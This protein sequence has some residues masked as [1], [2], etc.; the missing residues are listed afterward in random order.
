MATSLER[1][2]GLG[3]AIFAEGDAHVLLLCSRLQERQPSFCECGLCLQRQGQK[4]GATVQLT[5]VAF[6]GPANLSRL[7]RPAIPERAWPSL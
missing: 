5:S 3:V 1:V 4:L 7:G 6:F 2:A